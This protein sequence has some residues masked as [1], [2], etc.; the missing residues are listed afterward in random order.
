MPLADRGKTKDDV[1][2]YWKNS[3]FDLGLEIDFKGNTPLGNCMGCFM[4]SA[5]TLVMIERA[6]PGTLQPF[7][8]MESERNAR[9]EKDGKPRG[10]PL[11]FR[12]DFSY[13]RLIKMAKR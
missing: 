11:L 10:R 13:D 3:D 8:D 9:P 7:A 1:M 12:K 2:D 5:R 6:N 4:K